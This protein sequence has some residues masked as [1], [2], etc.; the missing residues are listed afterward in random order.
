MAPIANVVLRGRT[1]HFRRRIPT[2][3]RLRLRPNEMVRGL[4]TPDARTA[5]LRACQ[6]HVASETIFSTLHATPLFDQEN[7]GRLT[8][9]AILSDVRE[10]RVVQYETMAAR[11]CGALACNR[12][13]KAGFV[14][15]HSLTKQGIAAA[16]L[17]PAELAASAAANTPPRPIANSSPT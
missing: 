1:F 15:S 7:Q 11:N 13:K 9:G 2:G 3:L 12:L 16:D 14:T 4:R 5:K 10:C 17:C 6:L 8:R